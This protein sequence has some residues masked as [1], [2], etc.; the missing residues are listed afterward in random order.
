MR[1]F[2]VRRSDSMTDK[3]KPAAKELMDCFLKH[4]EANDKQLSELKKKQQN[5]KLCSI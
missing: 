4:L 1:L 3:N 2:Q 5:K